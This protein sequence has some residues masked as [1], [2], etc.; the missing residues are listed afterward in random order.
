MYLKARYDTSL[1]DVAPLNRTIICLIMLARHSADTKGH[2]VSI[3][4]PPAA[5]DE[6]AVFNSLE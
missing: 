3:S 2:L 1:D 4:V 6:T 5:S